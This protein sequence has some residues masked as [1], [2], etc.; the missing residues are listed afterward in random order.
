MAKV[1]L[2][3]PELRRRALAEIRQQRSGHRYQPSDRWPC[4]QQLVLV[5]VVGGRRWCSYRGS[6]RTPRARHSTPRLWSRAWL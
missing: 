2:S 3:M 1:L 6:R 4:C 5:C